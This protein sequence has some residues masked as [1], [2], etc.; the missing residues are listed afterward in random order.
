MSPTFLWVSKFDVKLG[1]GHNFR[2]YHIHVSFQIFGS[3]SRR[4]SGAKES[5]ERTFGNFKNLF[6]KKKIPFKKKIG[7]SLTAAKPP[8]ERSEANKF[9][10]RLAGRAKRG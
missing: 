7:I 8:A 4:I 9:G 5:C 1:G 2:N 6:D 10:R 3:K